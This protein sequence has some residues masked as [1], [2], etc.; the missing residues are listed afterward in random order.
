MED[1]VFEIIIFLKTMFGF[2]LINIFLFYIIY[3][4]SCNVEVIIEAL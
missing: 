4:Y 3:M 2:I 1:R